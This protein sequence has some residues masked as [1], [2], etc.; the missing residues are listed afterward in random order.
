MREYLLGYKEILSSLISSY[1]GISEEESKIRLKENGL[2]KLDEG[3]RK[4]HQL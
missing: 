3:K 1:G 2:N 4:H